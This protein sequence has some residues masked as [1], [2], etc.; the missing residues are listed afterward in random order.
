MA[1]APPA[2][3]R[4][5]PLSPHLTHWKWGIHMVVSILHRVTGHAMALGAV[6]ILCWWLISIANGPSSYARF[7]GIASGPLGYIVAIGFT[8]VVLQHMAN[9]VRHLVMDS[10][11]GFEIRTNKRSATS[12]LIFSLL[13]TVLVWVAI[14]FAKG[15]I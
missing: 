14:L 5:R 6:P 13:G 11:A 8:W 4:P 12:T 7:Y 3:A 15:A 9:G 1:S 2:A 10:G